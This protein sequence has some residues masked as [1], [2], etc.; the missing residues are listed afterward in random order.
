MVKAVTPPTDTAQCCSHGNCLLKRRGIS[1]NRVH[2]PFSLLPSSFLINCSWLLMCLLLLQ[3]LLLS[4][5]T[6]CCALRLYS[7]ITDQSLLK[8]FSLYTVLTYRR[9]VRAH[10]LTH[11]HPYTPSHAFATIALHSHLHPSL[12]CTI[13]IFSF[14]TGSRMRACVHVNAHTCMPSCTK[15]THTLTLT[16]KQKL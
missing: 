10:S 11:T 3:Y 16:C 5:A 7:C 12:L 4:A 15:H 6:Q 13:C 2:L 9:G 8:P 14:C 1:D